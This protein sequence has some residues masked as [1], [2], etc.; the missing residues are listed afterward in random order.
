M[1]FNYS[2]FKKLKP[3]LTGSGFVPLTPLRVVFT[4]RSLVSP[5]KPAIRSPPGV[6]QASS[7]PYRR[8]RVRERSYPN[9]RIQ[10]LYLN[11]NAHLQDAEVGTLFSRPGV[12]KSLFSSYCVRELTGSLTAAT[13][14]LQ[15]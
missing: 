5:I 15:A 11:N 12:D 8:L 3:D 6:T 7:R 14:D 13:S 9:R 1:F 4:A 2:R 10:Y